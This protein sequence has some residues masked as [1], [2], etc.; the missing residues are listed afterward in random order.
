VRRRADPTALTSLLRRLLDAL[1]YIIAVGASLIAAVIVVA[2][3]FGWAPTVELPVHFTPDRAGYEISGPIAGMRNARIEDAV[4]T[5]RFE[6][7]PAIVLTAVGIGLVGVAATLAVL[8][9][10]RRI[11]A[12]MSA[13]T[14]FVVDN[15]NRLRFV[16]LAVIVYEL[17]TMCMK[18]ALSMWAVRNLSVRGL[19]VRWMFD[20]RIEVLLAGAVI[21]LVA[22][23]F[24]VGTR[25]QQDHDLTI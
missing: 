16:G 4:G 3:V 1:W 6:A 12:T 24:R 9:Q 7:H 17:V 2:T 15:A 25:L 5:L 22:E 10:L 8:H 21:L 19:T 23:V 18:L 11:V 14:P 20:P 13:G